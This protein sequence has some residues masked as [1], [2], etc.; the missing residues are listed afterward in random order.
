M[1]SP[2]AI[3]ARRGTTDMLAGLLS[4]WLRLPVV[5]R[6]GLTGNYDYKLT[7]AQEPS[8]GAEGATPPTIDS[9]A[10]SLTDSGASVFTAL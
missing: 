6:T 4:N 5:N 7:Y 9:P 10:E 8:V 1:R 3:N 2:G